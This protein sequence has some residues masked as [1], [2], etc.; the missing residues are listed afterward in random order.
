MKN[1][2]LKKWH[3]L[4][5]NSRDAKDFSMFGEGGT[6]LHGLA[7]HMRCWWSPSGLNS[8]KEAIVVE[9]R[10]SGLGRE[11]EVQK[12]KKKKIQNCLKKPSLSEGREDSNER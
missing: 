4:Y 5:N 9:G 8:Y 1:F 2:S 6:I 7:G 11:G 12:W 10:L 3:Q